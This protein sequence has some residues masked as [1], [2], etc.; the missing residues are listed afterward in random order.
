MVSSCSCQGSVP[1][2]KECEATFGGEG[3]WRWYQPWRWSKG[4]AY[5]Q[6][7]RGSGA[8]P[9][10]SGVTRAVLSPFCL[11]IATRGPCCLQQVK[12]AEVHRNL[13]LSRLACM[14]VIPTS[15]EFCLS[16]FPTFPLSSFNRNPYLIGADPAG[17][18]L[19]LHKTASA[20]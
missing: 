2:L 6:H 9:T 15:N 13:S 1:G 10:M 12:T 5:L 18:H 8:G 16:F 11:R 4:S 19:P 7:Q 3:K 14:D 20:S 17:R